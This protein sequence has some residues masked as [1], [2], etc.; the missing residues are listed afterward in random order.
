MENEL[1]DQIEV[2]LR[3]L[4]GQTARELA[5]K[6]GVDR[7]PVNMAL[8]SSPKFFK[9]DSAKPCWCLV[10][11][12]L[13]TSGRKELSKE[14][15]PIQE[16]VAGE[17]REWQEEALRA[18]AENK[19]CGIVE[20]VT[21]TGKTRVAIEAIRVILELG[22]KV[23]V[24]VPT[25][26]LQRQ[27][28]KE[29]LKHMPTVNIGL[30]G[31]GN[32][33]NLENH[34]VVIAIVNSAS[35]K[36][37][38]LRENVYGLLVADECH[39]YAAKTFQ[40]A[41]EEEFQ[42]RLGLTATL[43]RPDGGQEKLID[44]F[45]GIIYELGYARALENGWLSEFK[46]AQIAVDFS[47]SEQIEFDE[48]SETISATQ[49]TLSKRFGLSLEP[50]AKFMDDITNIAKNGA[51]RDSM[52]A[53]KY[54][55]SIRDRKTLLADTPRKLEVLK[56]LGDSVGMSNGTIFFT[57]TKSGADSIATELNKNNVNALS[58]H[59]GLKPKERRDVFT[60][61]ESGELKAITAP[62]VL[63][64]GVDV[65]EADLA[66]IIAASKSKRQMIQRMGRILRLKTDGRKARFVIVFVAG[67]SEDPRQGAHGEFWN[68]VT[69]VASE[70]RM[71]ES[72]INKIELTAFLNPQK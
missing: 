21:G 61:F 23:A 67:T 6:L 52:A 3:K 31:D 35:K 65:P 48:L 28:T 69:D 42:F 13:A 29:L 20:A 36:E 30:L 45:G 32:D 59:S 1:E 60:N 47:E 55:S 25:K 39:G 4:P 49:F 43:D 5:N 11:E 17:L 24:I 22:V 16:F 54:L 40:L 12:P 57:E 27:W 38:G 62:K 14:N 53:N 70:V 71:F 64:Q 37:L 7:Y 8:Y 33:G 58:I 51:M 72:P 63:D 18:W 26:E 2:A 46:V 9:D 10:N 15:T 41:L 34:D 68:V 44:Y 19:C 50:F 66:V 56:Y